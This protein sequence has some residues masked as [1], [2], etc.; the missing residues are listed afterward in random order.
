MGGKIDENS[1][2]VKITDF[3]N[4]ARLV[5]PPL[6]QSLSRELRARMID[7]TSLKEVSSNAH[8]EFEGE[9]TDY[10][11]DGTAVK[12][13]GFASMAK[14]TITIKVRYTNNIKPEENIEQSFSSFQEFSSTLT[15][16]QVQDELIRKIV[17]DL[18]DMI[19]NATVGNW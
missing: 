14:L 19:Y 7:Q 18:V 15:L 11:V 3:I 5:Y 8:L 16:E 17:I 13:D 1:K 6:T 2:T 4:Q 9:I 10:R 12:E